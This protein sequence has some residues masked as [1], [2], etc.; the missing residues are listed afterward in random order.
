MVSNKDIKNQKKNISRHLAEP[1]LIKGGYAFIMKLESNQIK[2][3]LGPNEH[4]VLLFLMLSKITI[5]IE[6]MFKMRKEK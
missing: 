3:G 1:P 5:T 2:E 6:K 4:F